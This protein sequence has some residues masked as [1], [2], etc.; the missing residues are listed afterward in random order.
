MT[1]ITIADSGEFYLL[2]S[3][4]DMQNN[5]EALIDAI[6]ER[7]EKNER[8][9]P[10]EK[11]LPRR[12]TCIE[13]AVRHTMLYDRLCRSTP[14]LAHKIL[15]RHLPTTHLEIAMLHEKSKQYT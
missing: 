11:P 8:R 1:A 14:L 10:T 15:I 12:K 4:R 2:I 5:G 3:H 9:Q 6:A 7:V 13:Y